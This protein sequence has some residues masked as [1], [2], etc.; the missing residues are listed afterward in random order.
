[1]KKY[2]DAYYLVRKLKPFF[3]VKPNIKTIYIPEG[4]LIVDKPK[5]YIDLLINNFDYQIQT[6]IDV[7][8]YTLLFLARS[9]GIAGV[10]IHFMQHKFFDLVPG[11]SISK[12][13]TGK[14]TGNNHV[15][16]FSLPYEY[17][18][19]ILIENVKYY[20]FK[21]P[22]KLKPDP[23]RDFYMLYT[24]DK[25]NVFRKIFN[26]NNTEEYTRTFLPKFKI[27]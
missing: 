24:K 21:I 3:N 12:I 22:D 16:K 25:Y 6:E 4:K 26:K 9:I 15:D 19:A 1:M 20:A 11:T 2:D 18:G 10:K 23:N 8:N 13:G 14:A 5:K 17:S 27:N 7:P